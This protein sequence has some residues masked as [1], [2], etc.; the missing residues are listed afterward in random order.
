MFGVF[1]FR[2][3]GLSSDLP[4]H[5]DV[6][7]LL[8][9]LFLYGNAKQEDPDR[10]GETKPLI[11]CDLQTEAVDQLLGF[12]YFG[13]EP[14]RHPRLDHTEVYWSENHQLLFATAE[15]LAGQLLLDYE[16]Q[17]K[18]YVQDEPVDKCADPPGGWTAYADPAW[19]MSADDRMARAYPRLVRWLDHRLMFGLSEWTSPVYFDYDIAALLNLV[20]DRLLKFGEHHLSVKCTD[21]LLDIVIE[22]VDFFIFAGGV[23]DQII[24]QERFVGG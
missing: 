17:P 12:K 24:D 14:A 19:A 6:N 18:V 23:G 9:L 4:L 13:D 11:P 1:C 20:V 8:R 21:D 5:F 16:F 7:G 22:Q 2:V 15:Y 10:P 3:P